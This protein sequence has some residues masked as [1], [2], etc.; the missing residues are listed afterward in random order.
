MTDKVGQDIFK[1]LAAEGRDIYQKRLAEYHN[2]HPKYLHP[3]YMKP[4][5]HYK[6]DRKNKSA[7]AAKK[8]SSITFPA[9]PKPSYLP[10]RFTPPNG[11][12]MF[13][14]LPLLFRDTYKTEESSLVWGKQEM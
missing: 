7:K 10:A 8:K 5:Y 11:M 13:P 9:S 14:L 6:A 2:C 12:D 4:S 3:S 1:E